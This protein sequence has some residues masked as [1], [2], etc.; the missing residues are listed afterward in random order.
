[1]EDASQQPSPA[2]IRPSLAPVEVLF[3]S[4]PTLAVL[5]ALAAV[6]DLFYSRIVR[7]VV[8]TRIPAD[9]FVGS[10]A[11]RLLPF[12]VNVVMVAGT[13]AV[14]VGI[15]D[16]MRAQSFAPISRRVSIA[17]FL[18]VFGAALISLALVPVERV[19]VPRVMVVV[20]IAAGCV[21]QIL[22]LMSTLMHRTLQRFRL[23]CWL[24]LATSLLVLVQFMLTSAPYVAAMPYAEIT[25]VW[26]KRAAEVAWLV[27]PVLAAPRVLSDGPSIRTRLSYFFG[28]VAFMLAAFAMGIAKVALKSRF[29][30][31]LFYTVRV[32]LF[33]SLAP[34]LYSPF[35]GLAFGAGIAGI[36]GPR[37][38]RQQGGA[39]LLLW[40]AA[41]A[42]PTSPARMLMS[43]L[44]VILLARAS[45]SDT[46]DA[47]ETT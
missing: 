45:V 24:A 26:V 15:V 36:A 30:S 12:F 23:A 29:E 1:M 28:F 31:A 34:L 4:V 8:L 41:G 22:V 37:S 39:A 16:M 21:L 38:A 11:E 27:T 47:P 13:V 25:A 5:A 20:T 17:A 46:N 6:L 44:A 42:M 18:G 32:E 9:Q 35:F 33:A 2:P 3:A 7:V 43:V 19:G 40:L 10:W 14:V